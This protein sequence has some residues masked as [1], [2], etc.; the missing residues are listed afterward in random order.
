MATK[1]TTTSAIASQAGGI[2][3][4]TATIPHSVLEKARVK[5]LKSLQE[6][7]NIPGF[8]AGHIPEK[9]LIERVGEMAVQ[10]EALNEV[11]PEVITELFIEHK[12]NGIGRPEISV[13]KLAVGSDAE[14]KVKTAVYPEI[15]SLPNYT[16]IAKEV[17]SAT[18]EVTVTDEDLEKLINDLRTMKARHDHQKMH[19]EGKPHDHE[20][21]EKELPEFNDAFVQAIGPYKTIDEF[22]T[23]AR[24]SLLEEKKMRA[25][26]KKRAETLEK[27][28]ADTTV[29]VPEILITYELDRMFAR[30]SDDVARFNMK[31]DDYL[32]H[33]KKTKEDLYKE[34]HDDARKNVV[35]QL[36]LSQIA[37]EEKLVPAKEDIDRETEAILAQH[38]DAL[39]DRVRNY[40]DMML[41]NEKVFQFL[42]SSN[43]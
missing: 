35:T 32:T 15:T 19:E 20:A 18:E 3:E 4:L 5:A 37:K 26:Q 1:Y 34:W 12:V 30:L 36:V 13:T 42:E 21:A 38:K 27:I 33:L 39:P 25:A 22:K 41:T 2:V 9:V 11:L 24:E 28:A 7:V 16:K 29:D 40:V 14:I 8:R 17:Y 23:K 10:E 43:K 31:V 6:S